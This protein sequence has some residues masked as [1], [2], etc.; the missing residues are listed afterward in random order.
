MCRSGSRLLWH[1]SASLLMQKGTLQSETP[2]NFDIF[3]W[4]II[5]PFS[6]AILVH[7]CNFEMSIIIFW[8]NPAGLCSLKY[9]V[10]VICYGKN[11]QSCYPQL[12][13]K[14]YCSF[15]FQVAETERNPGMCAAGDLSFPVHT[16]VHS[17]RQR[18]AFTL[19]FCH[20]YSAN[21]IF[22]QSSTWNF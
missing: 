10:R 1:S 13:L 14:Y 21:S 16:K 3:T 12:L 17:F 20:Q 6:L 18:W 5:S 7:V 9:T 22:W 4:I 11:P 19:E 15:L 8:L 2:P